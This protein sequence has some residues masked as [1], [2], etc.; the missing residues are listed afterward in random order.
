MGTW[1]ER[2]RTE[3]SKVPG[4]GAVNSA[5][6]KSIGTN[7][8]TP[9]PLFFKFERESGPIF[10]ET[11]SQ[12]TAV[13]ADR[14]FEHGIWQQ[15]LHG[16][17]PQT[18]V[19]VKLRAAALA[20]LDSLMAVQAAKLGWTEPE[21]FGVLDHDDTEVIKLRADAKGV[22][23]FVALTVWPETRLESF[24]ASH[25]VIVTGS[26]AILRRPKRTAA[27]TVPFWSCNRL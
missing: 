14:K 23:S 20:F 10:P 8:S 12:S 3:I 22:V 5:V 15:R 19:G 9:S 6:Q 24:A 7:G 1:L 2:A 21:L 17:T 25:A 18:V 27:N 26:G 11:A 13:T 16:F 4:R